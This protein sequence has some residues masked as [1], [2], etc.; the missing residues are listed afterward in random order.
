MIVEW[1]HHNGPV[2]ELFRLEQGP[3][4]KIKPAGAGFI[5]S[6]YLKAEKMFYR[7]LRRVSMFSKCFIVR[8]MVIGGNYFLRFLRH[9]IVSVQR[10]F[11]Q[12]GE[13]SLLANF[14]IQDQ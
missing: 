11:H 6:E 1:I 8:Q 2:P 7:L 13:W 4:A 12:L 10:N 14:Q 5:L 9:L 3:G